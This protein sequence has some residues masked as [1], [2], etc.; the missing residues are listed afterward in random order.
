MSLMKRHCNMLK[1]NPFK[2]IEHEWPQS[3]TSWGPRGSDACFIGPAKDH[4]WF[5]ATYISWTPSRIKP[6]NVSPSYQNSV[7]F[8]RSRYNRG[9]T[10]SRWLKSYSLKLSNS[11]V[12]ATRPSKYL[13]ALEQLSSVFKNTINQATTRVTT[14][15]SSPCQSHHTNPL[16]KAVCLQQHSNHTYNTIFHIDRNSKCT[17]VITMVTAKYHHPR[18]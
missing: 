5:V 11:T 8:P 9:F 12:K 17:Q 3:Y 10:L 6:S 2:A 16:S 4:Y 13:Q 7:P 14:P 18:G 1:P 15:T